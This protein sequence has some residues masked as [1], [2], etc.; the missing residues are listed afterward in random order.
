VNRSSTQAQS[1]QGLNFAK[2]ISESSEA[3]FLVAGYL[4][5]SKDQMLTLAKNWRAFWAWRA[6]L[7]GYPLYPLVRSRPLVLAHSG[8]DRVREMMSGKF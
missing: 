4:V 8:N 5:R 1:L 2:S 7:T 6:T 3:D